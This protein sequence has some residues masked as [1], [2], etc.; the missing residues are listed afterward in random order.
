MGSEMA[1][2]HGDVAVLFEQ[3]LELADREQR[4]VTEGN[5]EE[6]EACLRRKEEIVQAL[7]E[8]DIGSARGVG[9]NG[10]AGLGTL[11][12]QALLGN[13][14]IAKGIGRMA[15][16]CRRTI[17]AVRTG[18]RAQLAYQESRRLKREHSSKVL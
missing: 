12:E 9:V 14:D 2:E 10:R 7:R 6:L 17:V 1:P 16:E 5:L 15:E 13:V 11:V 4:A 18:Q 8:G 3:L